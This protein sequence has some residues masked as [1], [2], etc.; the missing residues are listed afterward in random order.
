MDS[1]FDV[2]PDVA[3]ALEAGQAVVALVSTPIA[4]SLPWP[5]NL[6]T[7]RQA[8]AVVRQEGAVPAFF[9]IRAGRIIIGLTEP[10][11][12]ALARGPG[13]LKASRRDLGAAVALR[14]TAA[15]TVAAT[16]YLARRLGIRVVGTGGIGGAHLGSEHT[17]DISADLI[18]LA[19]TPAAVVCAGARSILDLSRT[20][21][22][23]E[24]YG[25]PV[26]GYGTDTVPAFYVRT[27]SQPVSARVDTAS[28][29][30]SLLRAHWEL[31][32][33]GVVVAQPV[34]ADVALRPD[35]LHGML[36]VERQ[37]AVQ[38]ARAG[39]HT[40]YLTARLDRLT[41]GKTLRA[42]QSI[43]LANARLAAQVARQ[44]AAHRP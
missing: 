3:A 15:T 21:E 19:R 36:E 29:A 17:F 41:K 2:R 30:A 9:A 8:E 26:L 11:L 23:L 42:Y 1:S 6:E 10:Q 34:A 38:H 22:I 24:T 12:E 5:A 39:D 18:E 40:L 35:E 31:E 27:S 16:M 13:V 43:L 32:G 28:D 20:A 44:L 25:V 4:H 37:A 14:R 33:A 7:A